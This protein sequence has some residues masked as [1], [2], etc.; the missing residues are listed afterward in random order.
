M[1]GLTDSDREKLQKLVQAGKAE[2]VL[3]LLEE[4]SSKD[5][6]VVNTALNQNGSSCLI[7]AN[8]HIELTRAL[9]AVGADVNAGNKYGK[10]PIMYAAQGGHA[11]VVKT[12]H[13]SGADIFLKD[14][15]DETALSFA[16]NNNK[17]DAALYLVQNGADP[18]VKRQYTQSAY[19]KIHN[20]QQKV[21]KSCIIYHVYIC[22]QWIEENFS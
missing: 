14:K 3:A 1:S 22:Y 10:T 15:D 20:P 9:L 6:N 11:V 13:E 7:F 19:E 8:S 2:P 18:Y 4:L 17:F 5:P 21:S 16:V 12:L